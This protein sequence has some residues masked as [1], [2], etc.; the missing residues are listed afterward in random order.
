MNLIFSPNPDQSELYL[1]D[2]YPDGFNFVKFRDPEVDRLVLRARETFDPLERRET[3]FRLQER[4]LELQPVS[5]LFHFASPVLHDKR[6][7]G[8]TAS[9]RDYY[10][11]THGPRL[12]RWAGSE[13]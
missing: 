9:P 11:T 10:R 4:L 1:S 13:G 12:W 7:L 5:S 3:L 6:L 2:R 8:V